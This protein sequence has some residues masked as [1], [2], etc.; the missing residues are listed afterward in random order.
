MFGSNFKVNSVVIY[1]IIYM[2]LS[3]AVT[4]ACKIN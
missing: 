4:N 3:L 2:L 1:F